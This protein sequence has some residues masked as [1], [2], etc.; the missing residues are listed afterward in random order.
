MMIRTAIATTLAAGMVLTATPADARQI[1]GP[2]RKVSHLRVTYTE[3]DNGSSFIWELNNGALFK[4]RS[5]AACRFENRPRLCRKAYR[6]AED[7]RV[8]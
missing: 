1:E 2:D 7:L 4:T 6:M 8:R 5:R 3:P